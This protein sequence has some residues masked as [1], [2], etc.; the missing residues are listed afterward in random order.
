MDRA[1]VQVGRISRFGLLEMSRQRLSSSLGEASQ[2]VCPRCKGHGTIRGVESLA[3]SVLRLLEE[4][5]M[6]ENTEKVVAQLPVNVATFLLNEKRSMINTI[7]DRH[8]TSII[9]I[10]N[11]TM[12]T[13]HFEVNRVRT[14]EVGDEDVTSYQ[15]ATKMEVPDET[16]EAPTQ[17]LVPAEAPA[18]TTVAPPSPVPTQK[19]GSEGGLIKRIFSTLMGNGGEKKTEEQPTRQDNKRPQQRRSGP[20]PGARRSPRGPKSGG[21]QQQRRSGQQQQARGPKKPRQANANKPQQKKD[22]EPATKQPA[23]I[24]ETTG[25]QQKNKPSDANRGKRRGRRGGRN[26][27][28]KSDNRTTETVSADNVADVTN[29]TT[30]TTTSAANTTSTTSPASNTGDTNKTN[31]EQKTATQS[32][33]QQTSSGTTRTS[34]F[35][36]VAALGAARKERERQAALDSEKS[37]SSP[38]SSKLQ[39]GETNN[40][41]AHTQATQ[42]TAAPEARSVEN[43]PEP[44]QQH[45]AQESQSQQPGQSEASKPTQPAVQQEVAKQNVNASVQAAVHQTLAS[46]EDGPKQLTPGQK[47]PGQ[48]TSGQTPKPQKTQTSSTE[49]GGQNVSENVSSIK[50]ESSKE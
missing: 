43:K 30:N 21:N 32:S 45:T 49:S 50:P 18:V 13:P 14:D 16:L 36:S 23:D 39:Q 12:E 5:A 29:A 42:Q 6:K 9:L 1:R 27:N 41:E 3:L 7:E 38:A 47:T 28:R 31:H 20:R 44:Q 22:L 33:E 17:N 2:I 8:K 10:P 48:A 37:S 46:N 11:P 15:M 34:T 19:T 26:R 35:G 24:Q 40:S 25:A 4:E